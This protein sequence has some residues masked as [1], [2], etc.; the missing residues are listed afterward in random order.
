MGH[1]HGERLVAPLHGGST[2][3]WP[4]CRWCDHPVTG[5]SLALM[6]MGLLGVRALSIWVYIPLS[7]VGMG[8]DVGRV[9]IG[10]QGSGGGH[11]R[12][13][14]DALENVR[15]NGNVLVQSL[16]GTRYLYVAYRTISP[17]FL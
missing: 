4:F 10:N 13:R 16:A 7:F 8:C 9:V 5:D 1:G 17:Q 2:T 14:R 12:R 11:V 6:E 15:L 3:N